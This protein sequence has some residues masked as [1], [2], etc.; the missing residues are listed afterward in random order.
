[1]RV[2]LPLDQTN[3][4]EVL[5]NGPDMKIRDLSKV[6]S[7]MCSTRAPALV[8]NPAYMSEMNMVRLQRNSQYRLQAIIDPDG[9]T[10]GGNKLYK[11]QNLIEAD[12]FDIGLTV[13]RSETEIINEIKG[14]IAFL[15]QSGKAYQIR[16]IIDTN[17]GD[18]HID[19]C[20]RAIKASK[21]NFD[22]ISLMTDKLEPDL[23]HDIVKN[24][25]EKIGIS[26]CNMKISG[27]PV[28]GFIR[29]DDNLRYQIEAQEL[30]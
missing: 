19:K 30:I 21:V 14:I 27:K 25:R 6:D 4:V 5:F 24:A 2:T 15:S 23:A 22:M 11:I 10:Y 17:H 8:I 7:I 13:G 12:G 20:L 1:M 29:H 18:E 9:K 16:W 28:D 3:R 26:K